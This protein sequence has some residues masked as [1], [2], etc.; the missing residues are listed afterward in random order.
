MPK[1]Q[2]QLE[3]LFFVFCF[4]KLKAYKVTPQMKGTHIGNGDMRLASDRWDIK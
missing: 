1:I 2:Y 3:M 4:F